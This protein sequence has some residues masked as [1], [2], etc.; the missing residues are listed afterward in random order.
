MCLLRDVVV[1][2]G[3][4]NNHVANGGEHVAADLNNVCLSIVVK[5]RQRSNLTDPAQGLI[6]NDLGLREVPT[7]LNDTVANALNLALVKASIL[8]KLKDMLDSSSVIRQLNLELFLLAMHRIANER[9]VYANAL[10]VTFGKYLT[11]LRIEQLILQRRAAGI[12]YQYVHVVLSYFLFTDERP[13]T[14]LVYKIT[15]DE[16]KTSP[17]GI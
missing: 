10:A 8:K 9:A 2:G 17:N 16:Q 5:R 14:F 11:R 4:S 3:V 7:T 6:R 15:T 13:T 12:D 1:E